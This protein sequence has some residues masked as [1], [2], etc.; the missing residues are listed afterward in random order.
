MQEERTIELLSPLFSFWN[1]FFA[2]GSD[3][4]ALPSALSFSFRVA[5]RFLLWSLF[6][7]FHFLFSFRKAETALISED[8]CKISVSHS[9]SSHH[10]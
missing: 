9:I 7:V 3:S 6:F 2:E 10:S 8:L 5:N 4:M 1:I